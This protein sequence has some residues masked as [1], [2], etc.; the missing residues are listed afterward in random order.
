MT[1]KTLGKL[2]SWS[3]PALSAVCLL[4]AL[5]LLL[6]QPSAD[7]LLLVSSCSLALTTTTYLATWK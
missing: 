6:A 4:G 3:F 5:V 7:N 1:T 2:L